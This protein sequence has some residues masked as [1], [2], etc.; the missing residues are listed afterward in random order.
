M[1]IR[2]WVLGLCVDRV[3]GCTGVTSQIRLRGGVVAV[4]LLVIGHLL[5]DRCWERGFNSLLRYWLSEFE[6]VCLIVDCDPV[7]DACKVTCTFFIL[8][9]IKA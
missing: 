5:H 6:M 7:F 1:V 3:R 2:E 9:N 4:L 8:G